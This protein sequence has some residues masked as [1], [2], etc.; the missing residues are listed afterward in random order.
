MS[1]SYGHQ[2]KSASE[3]DREL[4]NRWG[5]CGRGCKRPVVFCASYRY[6]TGRRG[7]TTTAERFVC[8]AHGEKFAKQ[9]ELTL[10][11]SSVPG[12]DSCGTQFGDVIRS[13][14]T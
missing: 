13:A 4:W 7:R 10:P 12:A 9:H 14:L 2:I 8:Q 3:R 11:D 1:S 5:G 6:V